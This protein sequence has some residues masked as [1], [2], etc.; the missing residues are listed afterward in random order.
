MVGHICES[1]RSRVSGAAETKL[2]ANAQKSV[3]GSV[4]PQRSLNT[5]RFSLAVDDQ[6]KYQRN[7]DAS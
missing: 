5:R 6:I 1:V 2:F 4:I 3:P 7:D